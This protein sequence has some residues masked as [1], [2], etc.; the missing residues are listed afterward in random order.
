MA[1][2]NCRG[3]RTPLMYPRGASQVKCSLCGAMNEAA[4]SNQLGHIR[5]GGCRT[6]LMYQLG[7]QSV[8]CSLCNHITPVIPTSAAHESSSHTMG[9]RYDSNR[10]NQNERDR[11]TSTSPEDEDEDEKNNTTQMVLVRNPSGKEG[12]EPSFVLGVTK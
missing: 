1:Q 4:H 5:C 3:C 9:N 10:P 8:K 7:A 2:L 6:V 11:P 12:E